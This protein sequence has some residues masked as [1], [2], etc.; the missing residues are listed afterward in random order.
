MKFKAKQSQLYQTYV[1]NK[2]ITNHTIK[3]IKSI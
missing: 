1:Q 2:E 3:F